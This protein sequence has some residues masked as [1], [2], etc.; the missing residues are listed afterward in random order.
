MAA[1]KNKKTG[2]K[3]NKHKAV[4]PA[5][6]PAKRP[7]TKKAVAPKKPA[8]PAAKKA[9]AKPSKPQKQGK[10]A[11]PAKVSKASKPAAKAKAKAPAP[12]AS[13]KKS[14]KVSPKVTAKKPVAKAPVKSKK[15]APKATPKAAPKAVA[16]AAP[17]SQPKPKGKVATA[18]KAIAAAPSKVKSAAV[19]AVA[20]TAAVAQKAAKATVARVVKEVKAAAVAAP[21]PAVPAKAPRRS[22]TRISSDGGPVAAWLQMTGSK[23]RPSSFIPA[24]PRAESPSQIAAPPATSDRIFRPADLDPLPA[25]RTF[26]VRVEIEQSVGRTHILVQPSEVTVRQ[27]DGIEWDFRYLGGADTFIDDIVV[28]IPQR[29]VFAST[30]MK[31]KN[32]G[33]S[34]PHRQMSGRLADTAA[35]G[36]VTYTIHCYAFGAEIAKTTA[37]ITV[38]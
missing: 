36:Q 25:I 9:Q 30:K 15:A 16:K 7:A 6:A 19:A 20:A 31:S 4:K 23:P 37:T 13:A 3:S 11:K 35:K 17:K 29:G 8:K 26:P 22:R 34:R 10:A 1:G 18:K 5:K 24:P 32:P 27:G 14:Q 38:V 2:S 33:F 12:K 28:E 21:K